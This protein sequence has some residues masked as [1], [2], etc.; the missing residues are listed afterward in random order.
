MITIQ[1]V[2]PKDIPALLGMIRELCTFH[3]DTCHRGLADTQA[4]FINGP[5]HGLIAW[6]DDA[7]VGYAALQTRWQPTEPGD[8]VWVFHLFIREPLRG[9]G[10]GKKLVN[11]SRAW[12]MSQGASRLCIGA[13]PDNLAAAAAYRAMGWQ[14][15]TGPFGPTFR[16]MLNE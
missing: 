13:A 14:E 7:P 2:T 5:M 16:M 8:T 1:D 12:A 4:Q 15:N 3:K 11:A 6:K 10:I 9:Q